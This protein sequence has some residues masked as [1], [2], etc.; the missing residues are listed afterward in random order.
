MEQTNTVQPL[1]LLRDGEL[2]WRSGGSS[3]RQPCKDQAQHNR[4]DD[5]SDQEARHD[6]PPFVGQCPLLGVGLLQGHT[7]TVR[8]ASRTLTIDELGFPCSPGPPPSS[9]SFC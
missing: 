5:P 4:R 2:L 8:Y 6:V 7:L 9:T 3:R 1:R